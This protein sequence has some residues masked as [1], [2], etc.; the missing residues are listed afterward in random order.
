MPVGHDWWRSKG[1]K[2]KYKK[3]RER[4]SMPR[5]HTYSMLF[6]NE[7]I[8]NKNLY[9]SIS[10]EFRLDLFFFAVDFVR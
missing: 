3:A 1:R 5:I 2:K 9:A 7:K 8:D 10:K 6:S 4:Y